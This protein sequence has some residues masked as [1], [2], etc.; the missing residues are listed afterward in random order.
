MHFTFLHSVDVGKR[1]SRGFDRLYIYKYNR[2]YAFAKTLY[3]TYPSDTG[4]PEEVCMCVQCV[5]VY[6]CVCV[7][8]RCVCIYESQVLVRAI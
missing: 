6:V 5:C 1:N 3:E 2:L 8:S 4:S 7:Y